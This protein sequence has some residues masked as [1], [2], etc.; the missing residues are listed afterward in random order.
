MILQAA[1]A[2]LIIAMLSSISALSFMPTTTASMF[3]LFTAGKLSSDS[4]SHL[5]GLYAA[6]K[7]KCSAAP[8]ANSSVTFVRA[9]SLELVTV[10]NIRLV[11]YGSRTVM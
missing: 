6:S 7:V 4:S 2:R 1:S 8:S 9:L 5:D 3:G 10:F 11:L